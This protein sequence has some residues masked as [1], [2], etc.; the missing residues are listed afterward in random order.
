MFEVS[1]GA[2]PRMVYKSLLIGDAVVVGVLIC[3]DIVGVRY[4]HEQLVADGAAPLRAIDALA[5]EPSQDLGTLAASYIGG[6]KFAQ[7]AR[8]PAA[9][10]LRR[11]ADGDPNRMGDL[12]G[13]L[14]FDGG[15]TAT[16]VGR[17]AFRVTSGSLPDGVALVAATGQLVGESAS[18]GTFAITVSADNG[19]DVV[20]SEEFTLT[21]VAPAPPFAGPGSNSAVCMGDRGKGAENANPR[22]KHKCVG[23]GGR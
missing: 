21:V 9:W 20:A 14:M 11:I 10:L 1:E 13:Y 23:D 16:G 22:A 12:L 5:I 8:G 18:A 3:V 15:F 2:F 19:A 7:R 17:P 4:I 6:S